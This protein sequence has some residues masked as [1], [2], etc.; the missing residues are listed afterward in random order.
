MPRIASNI[1]EEK[2]CRFRELC[3]FQSGAVIGCQL[4]NKSSEILS[5][6]DDTSA[7]KKQ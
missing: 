4:C 7:T 1:W 2:K 3:D 6:K 5:G